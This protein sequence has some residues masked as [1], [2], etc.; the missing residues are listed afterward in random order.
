M[1]GNSRGAGGC[2]WTNIGLTDI[3]IDDASSNSM[4]KANVGEVGGE[5]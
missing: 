1:V 3:S 4:V 5:G 2:G